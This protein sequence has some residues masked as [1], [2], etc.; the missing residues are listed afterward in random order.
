MG[1]DVSDKLSSYSTAVRKSRRWYH[2]A[3]EEIILGT[4]VVNSWLAYTDAVKA[5][6]TACG[7]R[8]NTGCLSQR[9]KRILQISLMDLENNALTP[10]QGTCHHYLTVS[11]NFTGKEKAKHR[12]RRYCKL[13]YK[14][15][16]QLKGRDA[17]KKLGKVN[18]FCDQCPEKPYLCKDCFR[19]NHK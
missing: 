1:I 3:A 16:A 7:R 19:A 12:I 2:K 11:Q 10:V 14:Q 6:P 8:K 9:S 5:K 4:V 15:A 17:A 18:T 13:C